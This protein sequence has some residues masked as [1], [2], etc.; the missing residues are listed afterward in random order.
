MTRFCM[1]NL[2]HDMIFKFQ[3]LV[4]MTNTNFLSLWFD[5]TTA[6]THDLPHL[7]QGF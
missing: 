7:K 1:S 3:R 2:S 6:P 5:L 4:G